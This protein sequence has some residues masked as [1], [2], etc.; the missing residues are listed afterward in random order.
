[1]TIHSMTICYSIEIEVLFCQVRFDHEAILIY[2][3]RIS[4][5]QSLSCSVRVALLEFFLSIWCH[6]WGLFSPLVINRS[7]T[8]V[9]VF[10]VQVLTSR[11]VLGPCFA[12]RSIWN[13]PFNCH[14]WS[15]HLVSSFDC[16]WSTLTLFWDTML[17]L[18]GLLSH[19]FLVTGV[20]AFSIELYGS[21][22]VL[23]G[24]AGAWVFDGCV[25]MERC[26]V[27]G[28]VDEFLPEARVFQ[29]FAEFFRFHKVVL[30]FLH[31]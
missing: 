23:D 12:K 29:F 15:V 26:V 18:D 2:F 5:L 22:D 10:I 27:F 28:P 16:H 6:L 30:Q 9:S 7:T 11:F 8:I 4:Y 3:I 24:W 25:A 19:I 13:V 20:V 21:L 17:A 14:L 1:M 31:I